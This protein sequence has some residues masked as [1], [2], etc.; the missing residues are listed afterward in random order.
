MLSIANNFILDIFTVCVVTVL[1]LGF[2][3]YFP[4]QSLIGREL[5][6]IAAY[7]YGVLAIALP[8][9]SFMLLKDLWLAAVVLWASIVGGGASVIGC[10]A[11]DSYLDNRMRRKEAEEREALAR[12]QLGL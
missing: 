10:Y 3:H 2:G 4:W 7:V 11:L 6:R 8:A 12:K 1:I 9:T 5:P